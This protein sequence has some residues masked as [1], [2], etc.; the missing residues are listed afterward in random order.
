MQVRTWQ[1]D[2]V[3]LPAFQG[4]FDAVFFNAVFGNVADQKAALTA[5]AL[6]LQPGGHIVISHPLGRAWLQVRGGLGFGS[7]KGSV[8]ASGSGLG[9]VSRC[10]ASGKVRLRSRDPTTLAFA[11]VRAT[12]VSVL[13]RQLMGETLLC[14]ALHHR[15]T[16][17]GQCGYINRA[18]SAALRGNIGGSLRCIL[19][20]ALSNSRSLAAGLTASDCHPS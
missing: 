3:D 14:P 9:S 4:P 5:A 19:A 10:W 18:A 8:L 2:I 7:T 13:V 6:R 16:C 15:L 17:C 20:A 1:G 12:A 11:A